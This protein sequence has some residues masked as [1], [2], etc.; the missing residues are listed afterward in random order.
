MTSSLPP[1]DGYVLSRK[2]EASS[3]LNYQHYLW[4][5][6]LQFG[7]HPSVALPSP[8]SSSSSPSETCQT[9][10]H[11]ADVAT[12]IG[13]W[14]TE[15]ARDLA[16]AR[17]VGFDISLEQCPPKEWLPSNITFQQLD[18]FAGIPAE[19]SGK[20]DV[21]HV[22]LILLV[23]QDDPRSIARNLLKML[24][25]GGFLQWEE[26]DVQNTYIESVD[27]SA[28]AE[29]PPTMER[30]RQLL[31]TLHLWVLQLADVLN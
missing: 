22:R 25:P 29:P 21:V 27:S 2:Y 11:I 15:L 10:L 1:S 31:T 12:G 9:P 19:W 24:K 30:T 17:L 7:L 23:V 16:S 5:E 6:T 14:L 18:L 3:R 26:L 20:F 4:K 13:I 28:S 8:S